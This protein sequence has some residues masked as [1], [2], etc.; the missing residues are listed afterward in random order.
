MRHKGILPIVRSGRG[1]RPAVRSR[2]IARRLTPRDA[3]SSSSRS[4]IR[5]IRGLLSTFWSSAARRGRMT[6]NRDKASLSAIG[7]DWRSDADETSRAGGRQP[8][9]FGPV[10]SAASP[11]HS[12]VL[13]SDVE[14]PLITSRM[15]TAASVPSRGRSFARIRPPPVGLGLWEE[16]ER[17]NSRAPQAGRWPRSP[18]PGRSAPNRGARQRTR[19]W[20][21]APN[22]PEGQTVDA[23]A[24]LISRGSRPNADRSQDQAV[25]RASARNVALE[26]RKE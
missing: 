13:G 18:G 1:N 21:F 4:V 15:S 19:Q 10:S 25:C 14:L 17:P 7:S 23:S 8:L 3:A 26:T 9:C 16:K 11:R 20:G 12:P 2:S 5:S 6:V 24:L 22:H